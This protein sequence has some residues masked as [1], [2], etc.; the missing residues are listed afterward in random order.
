[1]R[2]RLAIGAALV[3]VCLWSSA[4]VGIRS[5]DRHLSPGALAL[6]RLLVGSLVLGLFLLYRRDRLPRGRA[7]LGVAVCGVS[8]FGI[9]NV[10]LNEAEKRVD[11]GIAAH[12]TH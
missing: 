8:W 7:L 10:V 12:F 4:F 6:G 11:A 3:T 1:M 2:D 5:A 9:Y